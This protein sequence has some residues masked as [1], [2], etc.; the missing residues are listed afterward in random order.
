MILN[1]DA[2]GILAALINRDISAADL[3]AQTLDRIKTVNP[4]VNAIVALRPADDLLAEAKTADTTTPKGPLHGLPI[5]IKDL[6]ETKGLRSTYGSPVFADNIPT[7]DSLMVARIRAAGAIIIGK[8]NTPEFGLGSHS[9]NP[10][11]GTTRNPYD[12]TRS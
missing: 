1:N 9:Y 10:I 11:Y 7:A 12:A 4:A 3:M 2:T 8:T 5:A 6:A